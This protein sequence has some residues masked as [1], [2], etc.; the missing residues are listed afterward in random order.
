MF[1]TIYKITCSVNNKIYIGKHQTKDLNDGYMGSGTY[2]KRAHKKY[3]LDKFSK[4]ILFVFTSEE[5]MN[6]KEKDIVT[7]DFCLR[8]DTYNLTL[9]GFGTF[10]HIN[11]NIE[12]RKEKNS[13]AG[14]ITSSRYPKEMREWAS[15][16][17]RVKNELYKDQA[18]EVTL[19][20]HR[21]GWFSFKGKK[22]S[23][24]SIEKMRL[25]KAGTQS[26]SKNSQFGTIWITNGV[27]NKKVKSTDIIPEGW[28]NGRSKIVMIP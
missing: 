3:G 16:G 25:A 22:H 28:Y 13:R 11:S 6:T 2:L 21:E 17:A 18:R 8:K 5:E 7:E 9:G 20:G 10:H 26:G 14:K 23:A 15:K 1:Y 19:R 27:I 24:K 12:L 4:E